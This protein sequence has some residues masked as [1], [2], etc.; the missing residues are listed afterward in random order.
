MQLPKEHKVSTAR[1]MFL[2]R[3]IIYLAT[4]KCKDNEKTNVGLTAT[5]FKSTLANHKASFKSESK[6]NATEL[7]K[8]VWDLNLKE[9]NLNYTTFKFYATPALQ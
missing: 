3:D 5:D 7:S 2:S 1:K 9:R 8:Y 4:V 6:Q